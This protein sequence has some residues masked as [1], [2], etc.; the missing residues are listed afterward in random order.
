MK[1]KIIVMFFLVLASIGHVQIIFAQT[2]TASAVDKAWTLLGSRTVDYLIDRDEINFEASTFI[3]L[4]F[5]I[6]NSPL[7]MHK[8]ILHFIDG[9]TKDIE[10]P[11]DVKVISERTIDLKGSNK[12]LDKVIFWYDT[13]NK[14]DV[15]AIVELW[16]KK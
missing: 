6:K 1:S 5:K 7:S 8:C 10:F 13:N 9:S 14:A 11:D 12:K 4:K 15:K 2:A 3:E 16:G